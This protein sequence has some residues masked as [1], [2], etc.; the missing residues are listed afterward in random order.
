VAKARSITSR[1]EGSGGLLRILAIDTTT[2]AG[3]T[4]ILDGQHVLI[5]R[6]GEAPITHGERLPSDLARTLDAA[7]V[8]LDSIELLAV[9]AG[10]GSFTGLRV[11]IAAMQGLAFARGLSI[12]P[13]SALEAIA[14]QAQRTVPADHVIAAWVDAHRGEV[15]AAT[16]GGAPLVELS[17]P[18]VASPGDTLRGYHAFDPSPIFFAGDGAVRY[19]AAIT[20]AL[21]ARAGIQRAAA[22][23]AAEAARIA[24]AHPERAVTP[25]AVIPI[26]GR[27]P[28]AELARDRAKA[29]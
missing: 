10:P 18:T 16:Y 8:P 7:G 6:T 14:R 12:V 29:R 24:A 26:Y 15:F 3:S 22:P 25:G 20:E 21:G 19:H 5:E 9:V 27:R 13:V 11:G 1:R 4:A 28:D 2:R 23:L 17:P